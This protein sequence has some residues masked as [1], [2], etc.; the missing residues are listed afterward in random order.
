[1]T[2]IGTRVDETGTLLRDGDGFQLRRDAGGRYRL[3]LQRPAA[4]LMDKRVRLRGT[5][6]GDDLVAA[7]GVAPA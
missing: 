7:E 2:I 5:L 1:M 4:D 6:V 3:E